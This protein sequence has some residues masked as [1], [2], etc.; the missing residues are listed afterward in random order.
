MRNPGDFDVEPEWATEAALEPKRL[1]AEAGASLEVIGYSA[2]AG[3]LL[4]VWLFP[5]N[6]GNLHSGEWWGTSACAANA[7][8]VRDYRRAN[9]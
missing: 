5:K 6:E 8:D 7:Q 3:R 9:G 2:G 4:K 1:A